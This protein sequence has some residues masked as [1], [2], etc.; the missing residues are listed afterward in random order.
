V[1]ASPSKTRPSSRGSEDLKRTIRSWLRTDLFTLISGLLPIPL[2]AVLGYFGGIE[3]WIRGI[4][5]YLAFLVLPGLVAFQS[6]RGKAILSPTVIDV[7]VYSNILGISILMAIS[8]SLARAGLLTYL[9]IIVI[10]EIIL[11]SVIGSRWLL[12]Q[13]DELSHIRSRLS[14]LVFL[15]LSASLSVAFLI[16]RL[17]LLLNGLLVG[18]DDAII[19]RVGQSAF[20]LGSWPNLSDV[21]HP[22]VSSADIA[23]GGPLVFG[24]FG[25]AIGTNPIYVSPFFGILSAMLS[26]LA[27][28]LLLRRFSNNPV[29]V[30]GLPFVWLVGYAG[31]PFLFNLMLTFAFQGGTPESILSI[32]LYIVSLACFVDI[33]QDES[34]SRSRLLLLGTLVGGVMLLSQLTF[35]MMGFLLLAFGLI[36]LTIKGPRRFLESCAV[37]G[38]VILALFP[39]YLEFQAAFG[40]SPASRVPSDVLNQ[41]YRPY[42]N[43]FESLVMSIGAIGTILLVPGIA[44][45]LLGVGKSVYSKDRSRVTAMVGGLT[46]GIIGYSVLAFS[47]V[48]GSLL[49]IQAVRFVEYIPLVMI[50]LIAEGMQ[51]MLSL[52]HGLR[53]ARLGPI[54]ILALIA[55]TGYVSAEFNVQRVSSGLAEPNIFGH[56]Q[57]N[58]ADW[59]RQ[60][61]SKGVVVADAN[62]G[63]YNVV[64][65]LNF[66]G[67]PVLYRDEF[68]DFQTVYGN[69]YPF[70]LP[71]Y[72]ANLV[73]TNP[74]STNVQNAYKLMNFTYYFFEIPYSTKQIQ[75][76][77][78]L[79]YMELVYSNPSVEIFHYTGFMASSSF[80]IQ[81][82][83]YASATK[84]VL[85]QYSG[86]GALNAS[87]S[88]PDFPNSISSSGPSGDS[89]DGNATSYVMDVQQAGNYSIYLHR[90]VFNMSEYALVSKDQ[91][92][93]GPV[94]FESLG[95]SYG[96]P[97]SAFLPKGQVSLKLTFEGTVGWADPIDYLVVVPNFT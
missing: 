8:W 92:T 21:L 54:A 48:G 83:S 37:I 93:L 17:S 58:A 79:P 62:N 30:Y 96:S 32:P 90:D 46:V 75:A 86:Q 94:F 72:F 41:I 67:H 3:P 27:L 63:S 78:L 76:F 45:P 34:F 18:G 80:L 57:L 64:F 50:P 91:V 84:G 33:V 9:N 66:A 19:A 15:G 12:T 87:V 70:N 29:I 22:Y 47:V 1:R 7:A 23:P 10:Q 2:V 6:L 95:W 4:L 43:N 61:A 39:P 13:R 38:S 52:M 24:L 74:N 49:G 28:S 26:V 65:L 5:T 68:E 56:W 11:G 42:A 16:P 55:T 82:T 88:Y 81:A 69:P 51:R 73:L 89:Y 77:S 25:S 44:L 20:Q 59:L 85:A 97:V 40:N 36:I 60:N 53:F 14:D 35:L 31:T 71:F